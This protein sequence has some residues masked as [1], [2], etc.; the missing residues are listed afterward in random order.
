MSRRVERG[1]VCSVVSYRR[2]YRG[3]LL[4]PSR[5]MSPRYGT[6]PPTD[7]SLRG[8]WLPHWAPCEGL[9]HFVWGKR[10][11]C[12]WLR[13]WRLVAASIDKF[14]PNKVFDPRRSLATL[15]E[16]NSEEQERVKLKQKLLRQSFSSRRNP[17]VSVSHCR[18]LGETR[19]GFRRVT[20]EG[21]IEVESAE[22]NENRSIMKNTCR[23][24]L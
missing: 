4:D 14:W 16:Y 23:Y 7:V 12:S 5:K 1:C 17:Q 19:S 9:Q 15:A 20:L 2:H 18:T 24:L 8:S 6:R 10:K 11:G 13:K 22:D 21:N 3:F